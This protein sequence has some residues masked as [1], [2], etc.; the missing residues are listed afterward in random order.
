MSARSSWASTRLALVL[1]SSATM[2][3]VSRPRESAQY[4]SAPSSLTSIARVDIA[5]AM[6]IRVK[7]SRPALQVLR[8]PVVAL[9]NPVP[10][11]ELR[12]RE[13]PAEAVVR[14]EQG[15]LPRHHVHTK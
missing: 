7:T 4:S 2:A 13:H 11:A 14:L 8:G 12:V 10:N 5:S 15:G 1:R 6:S 3:A 9:T